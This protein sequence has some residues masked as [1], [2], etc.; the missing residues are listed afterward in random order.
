MGNTTEQT[1]HSLAAYSWSIADLLRGDFKQSQYGRI[2]LPFILLRRLECVLEERKGK[3][4]EEFEN[5]QKHNLP[6]EAQE[7]LLLRAS[8][9]PFFNTS[10][11]DLSKLGEL[12][13][14]DNLESYIQSFSKEV[15][16]IF[17]YFN[18]VEFIGQLCDADL[19]YKVVQKV[20]TIDL[21]PKTI[22]NYDMGLVFEELV[23][24]FG[25]STNETAGEHFTPHDIVRLTTSLVFT[26]DEAVLS[27]PGVVRSIY[28]PTAGSGSFLSSGMEY[29]HE[30]NPKAHI[31]IFGQEINAESLT[32]CKAS[33]LIKGEEADNIKL[34]NTLS[35]DQFPTETFDYMLANP[36]FGVSWKN[37]ERNIRGEHD[38]LGFDGRF[39]PGLPRVS[40]S[41]LLFLL[42][43]IRKLRA[44]T[45]GG[46]RIGIILNRSPLYTGGAGSG[47]SEIRRYILENDLLEGIIALPTDM[48]YNTGIA[49]YVWVLSNKKSDNKK[50]KVQLINGVNLCG[51]M[52]KSLGNKRNE[53]SQEDIATI[54][55]AFGK[56]EEVTATSYELLSLDQ[57]K[58]QKSDGDSPAQ[59]LQTEES[60]T[61]SSKILATHAF[62]YRRITIE[63]PL[64]ES[65]QFSDE[66]IAELR[67]H[68]KLPSAPM[69]WVYD[70]YGR[71]WE[72]DAACEKY[73]V[74]EE[75]ET[76]I[77]QHLEA[78]FE[79]LRDTHI[80][81]LLDK[82]TWCEQKP[83]LLKAKQ[84]QKSVGVQCCNDKNGLD[85]AIMAAC[86]AQG[87]TLNKKEKKQIVSAVSWKNPKAQKVIKNIHK[88]THVNP[89]YGMFA[90]EGAFHGK[91][92]EYEPDPDLR[93]FENI[94]LDP[95]RTVTAIN[96]AH[97]KKEILPHAPD[98]WIDASKKDD[99]DGE[100]G[101]V[102]YEID[103]KK[104]FYESKPSFS[105]NGVTELVRC[106][107]VF[108]LHRQ[109]SY[110]INARTLNVSK[111]SQPLRP[112]AFRV[113]INRSR[114]NSDYFNY[115]VETEAGKDWNESLQAESPQQIISPSKFMESRFHLPPLA[116]QRRVIDLNREYHALLEKFRS[117]QADLLSD[118]DE[119]EKQLA[120]HL[121]ATQRYQDEFQHKL[122]HPLAI[123]WNQANSAFTEKEFCEGYC[124]FYE[125]LG[126]YLTSVVFGFLDI[127]D[128][129]KHL[130]KSKQPKSLTMGFAYNRLADFS[131]NVPDS[132]PEGMKSICSEPMVNLLK[133]AT[134]IRNDISHRG[135]PSGKVVKDTYRELEHL[136]SRVRLLLKEFF[137]GYT[138][139][140][141]ISAV[142]DGAKFEYNIE[143]LD[144]L[145][146]N[147]STSGKLYTDTPL[148][149]GKLYL[150]AINESETTKA[151]PI[152]PLVILE[153]TLDES[154]FEAF[155]FYT[156][157]PD[158]KLRFVCPYPNVAAYKYKETP[159]WN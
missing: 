30:H 95:S 39:G 34:G 43:M 159:I 142:F 114:L 154:N 133:K 5:I 45:E 116:Y 150:G 12:G 16:E 101:V 54:T 74:L 72:D 35:R 32:I 75:Y 31:R 128:V 118:P 51:K 13:I 22:S 81:E 49:T 40:D 94:P 157:C 136:N 46:G 18:F 47:E 58:E 91:V 55:R 36:P 93:Y 9:L 86:K 68:P 33:M 10:L 14:K 77:R 19:L 132:F 4:L 64:R 17:E 127:E 24:R 104:I 131:R 141:P 42:H 138:M 149:N 56:F 124:K 57:S 61:F 110:Q 76:E 146:L 78:E 123:L 25:E 87:I 37:I 63:R 71:E 11:M 105:I 85:E 120:P 99:K 27:Q 23:R 152:F 153:E 59:N 38:V 60:K 88:N 53:I 109:G 65:Y 129:K 122:P 3:V 83:I 111:V 50:G 158:E 84:L 21:S 125:Y 28:D 117:M 80:K 67:F 135:L 20:K 8:G 90:G 143:Y 89:L 147:P 145:A 112:N 62:G 48:F 41:S 52:R 156:D 108:T 79:E 103:F 69:S 96:E 6:E 148:V 134:E 15:R 140:K 92:V 130:T 121:N 100:V 26:G 2:I 106:K 70:T 29:V 66:R 115:F 7:K 144:G 97:V 139:F 1:L 82:N 102:G 73:G 107:E 155:Y 119:F 98:A 151:Y 137:T 44:S 126:V 113:N